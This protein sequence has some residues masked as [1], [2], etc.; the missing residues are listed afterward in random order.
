MSE[1]SRPRCLYAVLNVAQDV[2]DKQL[3]RGYRKAALE[4][5]PDKNQHRE[6]EATQRFQEIQ[7]A[8]ETLKNPQERQ[9]YDDHRESILRGVPAG[10][11]GG[12]AGGRRSG[13]G[14]G[15]DV[16]N[17]TKY[18]FGNAYSGYGMD[19][20]GF[21]AVFAKVFN[22]LDALEKSA[23]GALKR[24]RARNAKEKK[25]K[26]KAARADEEYVPYP[27][28]GDGDASSAEVMEF[29]TAAWS[30][31]TS[32][33]K[34][35]FADP[36]NPSDADGRQVRRLMQKEN[37]AARAK[38]RR[39]YNEQVR[40]LVDY[41]KRRDKRLPAAEKWYRAMRTAERDEKKAKR[42]ARAEEE[43]RR[44]QKEM[45]DMLRQ[46]RID[47]IEAAAAAAE[48]E[49]EEGGSDDG[50]DAPH[51]TFAAAGIDAE[52]DAAST[53]SE[54]SSSEEEPAPVFACELC[55][56]RFGSPAQLTNHERSKKHVAQVER[57]R[58][59]LLK[60]ERD[61]ARAAAKA[62]KAA[63]AELKPDGGSEEDYDDE[64]YEAIPTAPKRRETKKQK[65]ARQKREAMQRRMEGGDGGGGGNS[66]DEESSER[67]RDA[68][69]AEEG[70]GVDDALAASIAQAA[71]WITAIPLV[72]L[73]Q[74]D[75][76]IWLR[77]SGLNVFAKAVEERQPP[78]CVGCAV[79]LSAAILA[80][81]AFGLKD[82]RRREVGK[83]PQ[84]RKLLKAVLEARANGV[85]L[86]VLGRSATEL[87][88]TQAKAREGGGGGSSESGAVVAAVAVAAA[89]AAAA[90]TTTAAAARVGVAE[91][92][93]R[94]PKK[95]KKKKETKKEK[96]K[97]LKFEAN[98]TKRFA[99]L[100][101]ET[102]GPVV[103]KKKGGPAAAAAAAAAAAKEEEDAM[104]GF[105]VAEEDPIAK[106]KRLTK[107][108][109]SC[110][111]LL[112][113]K[114]LEQNLHIRTDGYVELNHLLPKLGRPRPSIDDIE[115][116]VASCEKQRFALSSSEPGM[117]GRLHMRCNQGHS[118]PDGTIDPE[119]LLVRIDAARVPTTV[120]HG[121][122]RAS[123]ALIE[124]SGGLNRME[125]NHIHFAIGLPGDSG[126]I[127]GMR[128]K[129]E[130]LV[131]VNVAKAM[132][133]GAIVFYT[134]AN[135]V[136]LTAGDASGTLA[137]D[138]VSRVVDARSGDM[139]FKNDG[140]AGAEAAGEEEEEEYEIVS[141]TFTDNEGASAAAPPPPGAGAK[142]CRCATCGAS[143]PS[144]T[145]LFKH[146]KQYGHAQL[147]VH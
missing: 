48:L 13:G 7:H 84:Q 6:E 5:H 22:E 105:G 27:P 147:K 111:K 46:I 146:I 41:A 112:R 99:S 45:G 62:A 135:G 122:S 53:E 66:S 86:S 61:A 35:A 104:A 37:K 29:Y 101:S 26:S 137:L 71:G 114:A 40:S 64:E 11:G 98:Q 124:A 145:K 100:K 55:R 65:K 69:A 93:S 3:K 79:W 78:A 49:G 63:G 30:G 39:A 96:R 74:A 115:L 125:R 32:K 12:G 76:C 89:A 132:A 88:Q 10:G 18:F 81:P 16:I 119:K 25:R 130:V 141:S 118:Y 143:F 58:K 129:S 72:D 36:H 95:A 56:K 34:F 110:S 83:K 103:P 134:S 117:K 90:T 57:L 15:G 94:V 144:K 113:H 75:L 126:V 136:V 43:H 21:Y 139:L 102:A 68:A 73:S 87:E 138:Y 60:E 2:D 14:G 51:S 8:Y 107:I 133:D 52:L 38:A 17:L 128:R 28:F 44:R 42:A 142:K 109:R 80:H 20:K 116:L 106:K 91:S 67:R 31:F 131:Y 85:L 24:E 120:V 1:R 121:T 47:E 33:R 54:V 23:F 123:W 59:Q 108:S 77:A 70:G 82:I 9:W 92:E 140:E 19:A 50:R 4:W 127:S 97:R